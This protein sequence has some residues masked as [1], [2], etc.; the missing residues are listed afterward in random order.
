MDTDS[1][2]LRGSGLPAVL[3]QRVPTMPCQAIERYGVIR[4]SGGWRFG[5]CLSVIR[6]TPGGHDPLMPEVTNRGT[7]E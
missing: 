5:A 6:F 2:S 3:T 7:A 4:G 1:G